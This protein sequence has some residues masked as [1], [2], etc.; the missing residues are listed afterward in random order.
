M[1]EQKE[2]VQDANEKKLEKVYEIVMSW[3][4]MELGNRL[5]QNNSFSLMHQVS[6]ITGK[7]L[8]RFINKE[9]N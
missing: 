9:E 4:N 3:L 1:P 7:P 6:E 2:K 5:T 8:P